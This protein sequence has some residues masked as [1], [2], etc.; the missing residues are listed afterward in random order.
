[1]DSI[2]LI[3]GMRTEIKRLREDSKIP[4]EVRLSQAAWNAVRSELTF[5]PYGPRQ[6]VLFDGLPCVLSFGL[7]GPFRVRYVQRVE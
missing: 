5:G 1:M 3:A 2:D 6:S 4:T 7:E